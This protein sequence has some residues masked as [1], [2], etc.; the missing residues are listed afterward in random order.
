MTHPPRP[1]D[2]DRDPGRT[3]GEASALA[4]PPRPGALTQLLADMVK[5]PQGAGWEVPL[6]VGEE[7]GR[8]QIVREIGRGGFGVVYEAHDREL[9][10][11]VAFKALR[12]GTATAGGQ[13]VAE[14]EAAARLAHPNIVHLYDLG[15]SDRG[16]WLIMEL[17]R[18]RSLAERL[19]EGPLPLREAVRVAVEISRGL[20]HAHQQGVI[21][22]DLK[23]SNVFLCDDG[24]VKVLDF[25][26]AQVFGKAGLA[27]GTPAYMAPEQAAGEAGDER[28]DV[29]SLGLVIR[30]LLTG[31]GP[32]TPSTAPAPDE[33]P[34]TDKPSAPARRTPAALTRLMAAMTSPD[35]T[36]RP[37][38]GAAVLTAL[39]PV[40]KSLE[41][42][43]LLWAAAFLVAI[44]FGSA[45]AF[46]VFWQRPMPPGPLVA[47]IADTA[48]QTGDSELDGISELLH[49]GLGQTR[50]LSLMGRAQ[51]LNLVSEG[52]GPIPHTIDE[53]TARQAAL[54][55]QAQ[56]LIVPAA[57][58][59]ST[60][61]EISVRA[62]D[63]ARKV[64]LFHLTA[65]AGTK[66]T[67]REVVDRLT[68]DLRRRLREE[69][70]DTPAQVA[71]ST[72]LAPASSE[73]WARY[74]EGQ[75]LEN[76]FELKK[77]LDA[78]ER[79]ITI[80]PD[81]AL[82]LVA[83]MNLAVWP[84]IQKVDNFDAH[85]EAL[86]KNIHRLA[87]RERPYAELLLLMDEG[88]GGAP[89]YAYLKDVADRAIEAWPEDPRPYIFNATGLL[90]TRA[91]LA[92]ARPYMEKYIEL[93]TLQAHPAI[94]H[95]LMLGR[96]DEALSRARRWT[97]A[98]ETKISYINLTYVR[99]A[100]GEVTE[101]LEAARKAME[102]ARRSNARLSPVG[103]VGLAHVEA[104]AIEE[105][106]RSNKD[107]PGDGSWKLLRGRVREAL[108]SFDAEAPAAG[109]SRG[110]VGSYHAERATIML[111]RGDMKGAGRE[112]EW[113]FRYPR[114]PPYYPAW[115]LAGP[116]AALGE[117]EV[118][119][120][121]DDQAVSVDGREVC[122]RTYRLV[123]R[124]KTGDREGA[125]R[126]LADVATGLSHFYRGEILAELGR[127]REAVEQFRLYHR[128]VWWSYLDEDM[129]L[130]Y[131]PRSLY[132]EAAALERLGE[133]DE[134]RKVIGRLLHLWDRA[135][136][137]LPQLAE[138]K[139][140]QRRV[141]AAGGK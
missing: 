89:S 105:W 4:A 73:A 97:E 45:L 63:L 99:R 56:L 76:D 130:S 39:L 106:E 77:A 95:L 109:A 104:D 13:A 27:G 134:A 9:A 50:R 128:Q 44:A 81:F 132:F 2:G 62:T 114:R 136:P 103:S 43:K 8:F 34:A 125:L 139:A 40:Q 113:L 108:A 33:A 49:L 116:L 133:K 110:D 36:G 47:A 122:L 19:D 88:E 10:R 57:R 121:L 93:S 38:G 118:A 55:G 12:A 67:L 6:Q 140:L 92:A 69:P 17:L 29:Y 23:P 58:R 141:A 32:L 119:A 14:A 31:K 129:R 24:Q 91:D 78:Y 18:G 5:A 115:C 35:P 53:A 70:G 124:W 90:A 96:L 123:R 100:R 1:V 135:D 64:A 22:R 111:A 15:H 61:Y 37:A 102:V 85:R 59:V 112:V 127:D 51:L 48:N 107:V 11:S 83:V 137:D 68:R 87:P 84:N 52:G 66:A 60:G 65:I 94:D 138:A 41:P 101:A 54:R 75:R 131:Y 72:E 117:L 86:R 25:G 126:G 20:A 82:A 21:H 80:E 16:A 79:A 42:K 46:A 3:L 7:V 74:V 71:P 28:T 98:S 26:L 120:R 30:E